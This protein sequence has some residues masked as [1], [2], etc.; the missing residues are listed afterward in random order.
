TLMVALC[1]AIGHASDDRSEPDWSKPPI[2]IHL[3]ARVRPD[4]QTIVGELTV[5]DP[6]GLTFVDVLSMLPDPP[7]DR[8]IRRTF[9]FAVEHGTV[10]IM[11]RADGQGAY[12]YAVLPRRGD[13]SGTMPGRG[14]YA[15]GLWYPQPELG[16]QVPTVS[17]DVELDLP[18]GVVGVLNDSVTDARDA[19]AT[20]RWSGSAER[21]ALAVVP[22]GHI[23]ELS[24]PGGRVLLVD[25][26]PRRPR[27]DRLVQQTLAQAWPRTEAPRLVIVETPSWRRLVRAGPG[28]L[29]LSD[30]AFRVTG[31]LWRYH[32]NA[33]RRGL[34][35]AAVPLAD[36]SLRAFVA[37]AVGTASSPRRALGWLSWIP[38]IDSLLYD[39]N[40]PYFSEI[41]D[42]PWPS[43]PVRDDLLEIL[44]PQAPGAV[45]AHRLDLRFGN[46]T[47]AG[48][49]DALWS[50]LS[51]D[52]ALDAAAVSRQDFDTAHALVPGEEL[53]VDVQRDGSAHLLTVTRDAPE[54]APAEPVR[55][56]I[57]GHSQVWLA[58]PGPDQLDQA[59]PDRPRHVVVDPQ[60]DVE[61]SPALDRWPRRWTATASFFPA[62]LT[63]SDQRITAYA[64]LVLRRQY[65]TRWLFDLGLTTDPED[66]LQAEFTILHY[67]GPLQD[68][69]ARPVR[70]WLSAGPS[71][72]DPSFRPTDQA[73][74]ALGGS[75][76]IAWETRVDTDLPMRGHRL[77]LGVDGG[78]VPAG[79]TA[80]TGIA[81]SWAALRGSATALLPLDGRVVLAGRL[82]GGLATGGVQ[83]RLLTLGGSGGVR[84][85]P[86]TA[87]VGDRSLSANTE[88][89][90]QVLR[91]S[92]IPLWLGWLSQAQLSGGFDAGILH[93]PPS[94]NTDASADALTTTVVGWTAGL[95]GAVDLLGARPTFAGLMVGG[96][97]QSHPFD[98]RPDGGVEVYLRLDQS[99]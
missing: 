78:V 58:G 3:V 93:S 42:E 88:L 92:S 26:G 53:R 69:R 4:L 91:N 45:V 9:P 55:V 57:D 11:P 90:W 62:E 76:G 10:R 54:T 59:L 68:R 2:A 33:V 60:G 48:I 44:T 8:W 65:D 95:G 87:L 20:L 84:G 67:R 16:D 15:N 63:F 50:G 37:D 82:R 85:I 51:L 56:D 25:R 12:F 31:G 6:R 21:L 7:D 23:H 71:L 32:V 77:S 98:L 89:R 46:G 1:S 47:A 29:F 52:D 79:P 94:V 64:D 39:G 73:A 36:P 80:S 34:I 18:E 75:A 5:D 40:L 19:P 30:N 49:A 22:N 81:D 41:F 14:I 66:I 70:L 72:L 74:I 17:W 43:D 61:Q 38:E 24:Q 27:R 86:V 13:A 99:F 96:L 97:L 35:E 83:H 28:L